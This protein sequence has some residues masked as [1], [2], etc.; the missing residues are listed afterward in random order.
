[1]NNKTQLQKISEETMCF[2]RGKYI[3]D[4][5][6]DGDNTLHFRRGGKTILT[7]YIHDNHYV[8]LLIFGKTEREKFEAAR[9]EFSPAIVQFY[10]EAATYHDGK[11]VHV[12]VSDL[13]ILENVK[14][15]II[16]KKKPN[17]K[18][19]PKDKAIY[20]HC[21]HRCDLC[22][23]FAGETW[24]SPETIEDAKRRIKA[25]Y[26]LKDDGVVSLCKGC[27][28][29]GVNG[30]HDCEQMV[31]ASEFGLS[32]CSDCEKHNSHTCIKQTAGLKPEIH[33]RT[34]MADDV[35]WAILPYVEGQYGN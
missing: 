22:I 11:W 3:A 7:I 19:F 4:E 23:H 32:K 1:M 9:H 35:I 10:D 2:M 25:L 30:L 14:P 16:F 6:G 20:G 5:I 12:K 34:I 8:F 29:G 13:E 15:L 31:C 17:R 28:H 24:V 26:G 21:G 27:S 33:T 18:P